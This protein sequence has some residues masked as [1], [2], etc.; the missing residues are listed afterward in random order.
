MR[1]ELTKSQ[2]VRRVAR[3]RGIR[4]VDVP[5]SMLEAGDLRGIPQVRAPESKPEDRQ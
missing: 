2:I 5:L 1:Q 4:F 3:K